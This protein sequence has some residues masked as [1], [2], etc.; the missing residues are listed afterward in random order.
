MIPPLQNVRLRSIRRW[1]RDQQPQNFHRWNQSGEL[2]SRISDL[3]QMMLDEYE[4]QEDAII[5]RLDRNKTWGTQ[6]GMRQY[7]T[8]RLAA[9]SDVVAQYLPVIIDPT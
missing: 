9:W 5:A 2:E 8:E 3:D 6:D 4:S 1:L 7:H